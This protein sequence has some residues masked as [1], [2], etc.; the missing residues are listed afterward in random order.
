MALQMKVY[1]VD[2]LGHE[3]F[4]FRLA[5]ELR[6]YWCFFMGLS[7]RVRGR[8]VFLVYFIFG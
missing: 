1:C 2:I 8:R 5:A 7:V 3:L 6:R 4:A